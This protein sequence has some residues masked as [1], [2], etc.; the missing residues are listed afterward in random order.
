MPARTRA[1]G[2]P[3]GWGHVREKTADYGNGGAGEPLGLALGAATPGSDTV[4]DR[5]ETNRLALAQM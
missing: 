1:E 4:A 3:G 2:L 5:I